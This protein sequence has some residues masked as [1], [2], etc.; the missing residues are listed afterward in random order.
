MRCV[1]LLAY[2][3]IRQ[4]PAPQLVDDE[5]QSCETT[6]KMRLGVASCVC[7]RREKREERET[8]VVC[9]SDETDVSV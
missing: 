1:V 3:Y 7:E 4:Q 6:V 2:I 8:G 5:V 9:V